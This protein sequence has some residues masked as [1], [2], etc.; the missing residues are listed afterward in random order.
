MF[1]LLQNY[2]ADIAQF[3]LTEKQP[4]SVMETDEALRVRFSYHADDLAILQ[5]DTA[6]LY[7]DREGAAAVEDILEF[8][9]SQLLELRT[10]DAQLD[11][12]LD[13]I[14][15]S[16]PVFA[17]RSFFGRKA[18][19]QASALRYLLVD[20]LELIDRSS[21]ALKIIGDAYYARVYRAAAARLGLTDW[22]HQLDKK[23]ESVGDFYRYLNDSARGTRDEFLE[24]II[25]LLIA[26]EIVI[27]VLALHH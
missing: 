26:I 7:D 8:A 16:K 11:K 22:Q 2:G 14:Y 27:G 4:L 18:S 23:L 20:V 10:Y 5:W 24:L 12:E 19:E 1:R 17:V 15:A 9:N 6:L 21:N 3:L 25:I 13:K